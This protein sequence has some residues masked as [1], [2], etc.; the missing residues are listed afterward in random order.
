MFT[1]A[2]IKR[3][4]AQLEDKP[5]DRLKLLLKGEAREL[6]GGA[7][8]AMLMSL[9]FA[10]L[11]TLLLPFTLNNI[12]TII[13]FVVLTGYFFQQWRKCNGAHDECMGY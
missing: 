12:V 1:F 6:T 11:L 4:Y 9:C 8:M 2:Q 10:I 7:L 13:A 5:D 3:I